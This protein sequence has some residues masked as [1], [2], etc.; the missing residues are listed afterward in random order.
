MNTIRFISRNRQGI[1]RGGD[2]SLTA[3]LD[4]FPS[5]SLLLLLHKEKEKERNVSGDLAAALPLL[6]STGDQLF[7]SIVPNFRFL[8]FKQLSP[9]ECFT[10]HSKQQSLGPFK[11]IHLQ[12]HYRLVVSRPLYEQTW[13]TWAKNKL[14]KTKQMILKHRQDPYFIY[15]EQVEAALEHYLALYRTI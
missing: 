6:E 2:G 13:P 1:V 14:A 8:H 4:L 12:K 15:M 11:S 9:I 7:T 5:S 3:D 10:H